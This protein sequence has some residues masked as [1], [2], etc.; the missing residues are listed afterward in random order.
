[1]PLL[2]GSGRT[3][4]RAN[5][6]VRGLDRRRVHAQV[7]L[8][9]V[10]AERSRTGAEIGQTAVGD[11]FATVGAEQRIESVEIGERARRRF[12]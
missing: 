9:Q 11:A 8:C 10:E 7:E 1:M 4:R 12:S 5:P 3:E 6:V 2:R